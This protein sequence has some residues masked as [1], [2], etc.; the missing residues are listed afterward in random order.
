MPSRQLRAPV[1]ALAALLTAVT[2]APAA[3]ASGAAR[4]GSRSAVSASSSA[5]HSVT[6]ADGSTVRWSDDGTGTLTAKDGTTRPFPVPGVTG[7]S[8]LGEQI[9]PSAAVLQRRADAAKSTPYQVA[10][11][12]G[13]A[14][15]AVRPQT[16]NTGAVELPRQVRSAIDDLGGV[17]GPAAGARFGAAG[18]TAGTI[19][20]TTARDN[21]VA[22][23]LPTNAGLATSFQSYL[24]AG[25]V[26]AVGAFQD[27]A[28]YLHALPGAGQIITNVSLGDLTDQSMADAGDTY[29]RQNGPTTVLR[30]GRRYLD[31]PSLPLIPTYTSDNQGRLDPAGTIEG[32]DPYLGEVLLDFSMMAPLPHDRQ[33]PEATGSGA[34]D[35]LG[36]APGA[37]YRLVVPEEPSA[38][39]IAAALRAAAAQKPRPDVI[40][41]SLGFGTD[42]SIG[43]PSRWLE[44]DPE[45]RE[46]LRQIVDSG[47]VVVV[48]ANDGTRLGLPVSV[49]P[50]G[51][52]T[53]TERTAGAKSETTIDDVAAT[54]VPSKVRDTGVIAA[55]GSTT[56]DTLTSDDIRTSAYPTTRYNGTAG[57]S[58][59]FGSRVDLA[60]PGDNL[61]SLMHVP[62]GAEVV[63]NGGTSASAPMIAAAAANVLSAAESTGQKLTPRQVRDLL[64]DTGRPLAQPPQADQELTMGPQLDVTAAVEKVLAEKHDIKPAAARLSVA[65][66]QLMS[67]TPSTNFV[68]AT[69]P[70]AIDLGG[71]RDDEGNGNGQNAVSPITLGLD[72]TGARHGLTYRLR[73]DGGRTIPAPGP[74]LRLLPGELFAAAGLPLTSDGPRSL[75]VTFEALDHGRVVASAGRTLTFT[76]TDGSYLQP[77]APTAPGTTPLG[78]S[79]T[80]HYDLTGLRDTTQPELVLSS[81]GHWTPFT[82]A[83]KWRATWRTPLTATRGT[84]TIPASA[85]APGGAGLYGVGITLYGGQVYG[86]FRAL[87]IGAGADQRPEAPRLG[88]TSATG[89]SAQLTRAQRTLSLSWDV[90]GVRGANGAAVEF[91]TPGPTLYGALNTTTNQNGSGRDDNGVD[92]ASTLLRALPS[93]KGQTTLDLQAL[94]LPT[95][96]QYPVR[97]I[98]TRDG[99]P[100]GQASPTS[101]LEYLDGDT[102]SGVLENFEVTGDTALLATDTFSEENELT[103]GGVTGYSLGDGS[104]GSAVSTDNGSGMMR[105]VVGADPTTGTTLIAR[106]PFT[107]GV[108]PEIDLRDTRTGAE[109]RTTTLD[110]QAGT[111]S[112]YYQGG[113]LDPARH[114]AVV[115]TYNAVSGIDQ[116]WTVDM[117]SGKVSEPLPVNQSS[118]GRAFSNVSLDASTGTFFV[119]TTGTQGPCLSGRVPYAAVSFDP[120]ARTVSPM[121]AMPLC[122]AG[123]LPDG[124]GDKVY[125]AAGPATPDYSSGS[126]PTGTWRTA[127][128]HTLATG[129]AADLGTRGVAWPVLDTRHNVAVVAHLY[130]EATAGDNNAL[131]EITVVEPDTGKV[132]ARYPLVNLVNT[133]GGLTNFEPTS[134]RGLHLDPGTRTVY[135]V[136]PWANGLQRL[137][138]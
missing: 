123:L 121:G 128:Q 117:K 7:S 103:G 50:D 74:S 77:Q 64:V 86:D 83:D 100:V 52:S 23:S 48:S 68:E 12:V 59:G 124:K 78:R 125:V 95:G 88:H 87:T 17:G 84:V 32:Q 44:D 26:D 6:L 109:V 1:A 2:A 126:F 46:T 56:D 22:S 61:P 67:V 76:A 85:F 75:K 19:S 4:P 97:I 107:G 104:L 63:L 41:A 113:A 39:G 62:D 11:G 122:T 133:M 30:N 21:D 57:Y 136:N 24:N 108:L 70:D 60:A 101:F 65:E 118:P 13:S 29:V 116:L 31:Y 137:T 49:G 138:Y 80:V 55:G 82:A 43:F 71:P 92:H 81:V 112:V 15:S 79:V 8:G 36:I 73:V 45:I 14:S 132:L 89:Y 129:T 35:L 127:D 34:T 58:S 25:G 27:T 69:D 9:A 96:V 66:R 106:R 131:S 91:L 20:G 28:T 93:A 16:M 115:V 47:I 94:G 90:D 5:P 38:T 119:A 111:T 120:G 51:G 102:V 114:R 99:K 130:E 105:T 134:L 3:H 54:T 72:L 110:P 98:A 135:L 37:D 42:G 10:S 40:T 18:S 33:R 53:P